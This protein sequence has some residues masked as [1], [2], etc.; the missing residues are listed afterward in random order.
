MIAKILQGKNLHKGYRQVVSNKGSCGVDLMQVNELQEHLSIHQYKLVQ[1]IIADK[2][3]PI[4]I[5]GVEI[6]KSNG[7]N[8]LLGIYTVVDRWLQQAVSQRLMTRFE[9]EFSDYNYGFRP[10][11]NMQQAQT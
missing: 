11:K 1:E 9:L 8:R 2:Y 3:L 6:P 4:A 10:K 7:K 5:R